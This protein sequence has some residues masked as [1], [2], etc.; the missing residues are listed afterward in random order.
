M[1]HFAIFEME[2]KIDKGSTFSPQNIIN[3][4]YRRQFKIISAESS[5]PEAP[6]TDR[7]TIND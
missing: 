1:N 5:L 4:I 3:M 6:A 7:E 2:R